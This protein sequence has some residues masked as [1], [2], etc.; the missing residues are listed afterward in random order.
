MAANVGESPAS[1]EEL[2]RIYRALFEA[3]HD[4]IVLQDESFRIVDINP[5]GAALTGYGL[6]ELRRMSASRDLV[7]AEDFDKIRKI[8]A[9]E[10]KPEFIKCIEGDKSVPKY[11]E[12]VLSTPDLTMPADRTRAGMRVPGPHLSTRGGETWS[13]WPPNSS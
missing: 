12:V 1:A 13:H 4:V 9:N 8:L 2:G 3:S 10:I 11:V 6:D 5:R 7:V